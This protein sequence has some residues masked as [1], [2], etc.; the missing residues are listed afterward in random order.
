MPSGR[1][2]GEVAHAIF[3]A[4]VRTRTDPVVEARLYLAVRGVRIRLG[5]DCI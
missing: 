5:G 4:Y 1:M 2:P 3:D